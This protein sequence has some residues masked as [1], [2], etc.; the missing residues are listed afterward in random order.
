MSKPKK[1][2]DSLQKE[3]E[4]KKTE[5][6]RIAWNKTLKEFYKKKSFNPFFLDY[7]LIFCLV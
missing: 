2:K 4:K 5:L 1:K 3:E 7:A 6:A